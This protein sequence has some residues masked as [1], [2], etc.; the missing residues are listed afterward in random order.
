[1]V[2]YFVLGLRCGGESYE[3]ERLYEISSTESEAMKKELDLFTLR[4]LDKVSEEESRSSYRLLAEQII[5]EGFQLALLLLPNELP[6]R[7]LPGRAYLASATGAGHR[8]LWV[9]FRKSL[10]RL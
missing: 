5:R 10:N 7:D 9:R 6:E 8:G 2:R 4:T 1:M 3:V